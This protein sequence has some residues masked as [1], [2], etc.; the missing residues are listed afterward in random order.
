MFALYYVEQVSY[1][2]GDGVTLRIR[3]NCARMILN[4]DLNPSPDAT[5]NFLIKKYTSI[6]LG[7]NEEEVDAVQDEIIDVIVGVGASA[8]D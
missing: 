2:C 7:G 6:C 8:F 3:W 1:G 5:E 4:L